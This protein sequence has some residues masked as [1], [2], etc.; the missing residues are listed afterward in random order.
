MAGRATPARVDVK[1]DKQ[2]R[3]A[4]KHLQGNVADLREVHREAGQEVESEA[5]TLVPIDT[6]RLR[7]TIRLSIR[8][9]GSKSSGTQILAGK[10]SMVPY[11]GPIHFGW[12]ARN[13]EPQPFLEDATDDRAADV[14]QAYERKV[15]GDIKRF[16]REAPG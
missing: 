15:A 11:A 1:G 13:I 5:R 2:L 12:R 8:L 3:T 16:D 10:G 4:F 7:D 6:G 9:A 14:V